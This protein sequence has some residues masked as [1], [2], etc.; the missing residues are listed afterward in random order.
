MKTSNLINSSKNNIIL[1]IYFLSSGL[2]GSLY[3]FFLLY[4]GN[5]LD[6]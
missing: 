1:K 2:C 4:N 5:G 6:T 3:V